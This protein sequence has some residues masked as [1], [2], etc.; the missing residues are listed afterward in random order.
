MCINN[1]TDSLA[2]WIPYFYAG[3]CHYWWSLGGNLNP[4]T[5]ILNE[6]LLRMARPPQ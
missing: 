3:M 5:L 6:P 1:M 2:D 4:Q